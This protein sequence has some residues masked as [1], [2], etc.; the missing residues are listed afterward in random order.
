MLKNLEIIVF[1][2]NLIL[3]KNSNY[4]EQSFQSSDNILNSFTY[5]E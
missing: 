4:P 2:A 3:G 5:H 1:Y